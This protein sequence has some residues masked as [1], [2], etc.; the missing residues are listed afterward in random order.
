MELL[1]VRLA[2]N[3]SL[4]V[5]FGRRN[6]PLKA[7]LVDFE[8]AVYKASSLFR[9]LSYEFSCSI[10]C[11][12]SFLGGG[13]IHA[14][15][16]DS[17]RVK[18]PLWA[19]VAA[20]RRIFDHW[21]LSLLI[22]VIIKLFWWT[23]RDISYFLINYV[24]REIKALIAHINIDWLNNVSWWDNI[25]LGWIIAPLFSRGAVTGDTCWGSL[26]AALVRLLAHRWEWWGEAELLLEADIFLFAMSTLIENWRSISRLWAQFGRLGDLDSRSL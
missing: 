26:S 21:W 3:I 7:I 24:L 11:H 8:V 20:F 16:V 12:E 18:Y 10:W 22:L 9:C 19:T 17:L 13:N 4:L 15:S 1:N 6:I 23:W 14:V 25:F 5:F 2:C